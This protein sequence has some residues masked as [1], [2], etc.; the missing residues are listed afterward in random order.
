MS[1]RWTKAVHDE[2]IAMMVEPIQGEGGVVTPRID[3]LERV[4]DLCD[5]RKILL[6]LDEVQIGMGRTGKLFA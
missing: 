5:R 3:Y 6:I 4:R 1:K 2:T